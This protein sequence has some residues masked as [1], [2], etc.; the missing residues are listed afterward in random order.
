M[1]NLYDS[2]SF[3]P[4]PENIDCKKPFDALETYKPTEH[5]NELLKVFFFFNHID[6]VL[7]NL[8]RQPSLRKVGRLFELRFSSG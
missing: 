7:L 4:E 6:C 5:F 8:N 2:N 1:F 3:T